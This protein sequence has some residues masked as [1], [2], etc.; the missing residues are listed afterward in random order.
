MQM[1]HVLSCMQV[2]LKCRMKDMWFL[3]SLGYNMLL[4]IVC[5]VYAIKTR[6]IPE[7]FNESKHIGFAMYTTCV[8]WLAFIPIYFGTLNSYQVVLSYP[9][10]K[11]ISVTGM[12]LNSSNSVFIKHCFLLCF[13]YC[14][15][16]VR[17]Y[18]CLSVLLYVC[19]SSLSHS[20]Y[21]C[22]NDVS[23]SCHY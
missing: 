7:N 22:N 10:I 11:P 3:F 18:V 6:K 2:V 19:P 5:T 16:V 17:L 9:W 1:N 13:V 21:E 23:Y 12:L 8:I 15:T 4:I 14:Y 20:P